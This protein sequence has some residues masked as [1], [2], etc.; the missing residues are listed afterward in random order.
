M[1]LMV[2]IAPALGGDQGDDDQTVGVTVRTP[3]LLAIDVDSEV[4]LGVG[5]PG[6]STAE[7]AF[8][9]GIVNDTDEGWEV[10]VAAT[11]FESVTREC[12]EAGENC[13]QTPTDP[14]H[15]IDVG[16]LHI[17]GG[18]GSDMAAASVMTAGD[19][20]FE[21][22]GA[23]FRLLAGSHAAAGTFVVD[24]PQTA[25]WLDVPSST[26]DGEYSATLTYTIMAIAP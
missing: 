22:A 8:Q 2:G 19:G 7:V 1:A 17:R 20:H 5:A 12:D 23:S 18:V 25:M 11:D 6:S 9:I 15:R 14:V 16:N 3:G 21:S 24:D 13:T 26:P 4:A 10:Y